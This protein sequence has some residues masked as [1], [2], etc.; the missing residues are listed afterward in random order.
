MRDRFHEM[1]LVWID[2][3][4]QKLCSVHNVLTEL[5]DK[6]YK[7][8]KQ[9]LGDTRNGRSSAQIPVLCPAANLITHARARAHP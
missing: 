9:I 6:L 2:N 5:L 3:V 1:L 8:S 7:S 4:Q